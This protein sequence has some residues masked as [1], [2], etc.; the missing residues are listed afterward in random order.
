MLA[1]AQN[2]MVAGWVPGQTANRLG[3][4]LQDRQEALLDPHRGLSR[5]GV[6]PGMNLA[7]ALNRFADATPQSDDLTCITLYF[8]A[9]RPASP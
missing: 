1:A 3:I 9:A 8:N 6:I 4:G 5:L 7:R 2:L